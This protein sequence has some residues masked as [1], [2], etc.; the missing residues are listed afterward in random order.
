MA[1]SNDFPNA[2]ELASVR[3]FAKDFL[4]YLYAGVEK[5]GN[6]L[7][8][9]E[10]I[11][12]YFRLIGVSPDITHL[13][14]RVGRRLYRQLCHDA[15]EAYL[16]HMPGVAMP[17]GKPGRPRMDGEAEQLAKQHESKS[18]RQIAI[19][20]LT[21][22]GLLP[23]SLSSEQKELAIIKESERIRKLLA[24]RRAKQ[25]RKKSD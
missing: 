13:K 14:D 17:G 22:A 8:P 3:R 20:Q 24:S 25:P 5:D 10:A 15:V 9:E 21:D 16:R 6:F 4:E 18:Y 19:A 2:K 23:S 1:S 12:A 7:L 11:A